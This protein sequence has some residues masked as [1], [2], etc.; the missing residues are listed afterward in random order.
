MTIQM[1]RN[2]AKTFEFVLFARDFTRR[3]RIDFSKAFILFISV[4]TGLCRRVSIFYV[5][6][7]PTFDSAKY[8]VLYSERT[9]CRP[10]ADLSKK[11][12]KPLQN[13]GKC[14]GIN[15]TANIDAPSSVLRKCSE[16]TH[17]N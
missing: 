8:T 4:N 17:C 5:D 10:V 12:K 15:K 3:K 1:F 14:N 6:T 9:D 2:L 7:C 11:K 16:F 13:D